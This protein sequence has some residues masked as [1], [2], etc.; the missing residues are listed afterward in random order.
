MAHLLVVDDA[1]DL[2]DVVARLLRRAGHRVATA[3]DGAAALAALAGRPAADRFDAVLLDVMM[4]GVDGFD[5]L[6]AVRADPRTAG[7]PVALFTA[8]CDAASRRR[9]AELGADAYLVKGRTGYDELTA[10][11]ARLTAPLQACG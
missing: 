6:R 1:P 9:A 5:V 2:A 3:E 4:P 10:T 8:V 11:V 7:L